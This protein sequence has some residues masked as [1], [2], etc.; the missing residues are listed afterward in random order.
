LILLPKNEIFSRHLG[1]DTV[2]N[3]VRSETYAVKIYNTENKDITIPRIYLEGG[4]AS[5]YRI[6]VDG[7]PGTEF[8]NV[9]LRKKDSLYVFVEIAPQA[10]AT[11]AIAEDRVQIE[12]PLPNNILLCFLWFKMQNFMFL[13]LLILRLSI[14]IP[15]GIAIKPKLFMVI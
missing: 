4:A 5:P 10:N 2:Y 9:P 8:T 3:Q 15:F 7:K 13:L 12:S 11:E 6:N 1:L 14:K